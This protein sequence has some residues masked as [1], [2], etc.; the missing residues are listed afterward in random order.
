MYHY[1]Y[2]CYANESSLFF[3]NQDIIQSKE[4]VQQG[5]PLGPFLF[6]LAINDLVSSCESPLNLWYLDDRTLGGS[7]TQ[8]IQD[9]KRI[10]EAT[11]NLG[12]QINPGKCE[13]YLVNPLLEECKNALD[14]FNNVTPGVKLLNKANLKLLGAP[15][16]PEAIDSILE[17]KLENLILMANRLKEIDAHDA[18]FLLRNCFSMPKLTYHL[19]TSPCFLKKETLNKYDSIIKESLQD[20]LNVKLD[21]KGWDQSSLPIKFGGLGIKLASEVALPAYLSSVYSSKSTVKSLIPASI[22]ED[23]NTFYENACTEWKVITERE[24]IP[25]NPNF[26]SEWD[27]PIYVKRYTNLIHTAPTR[28]EKARLLAVSSENASDFLYALPIS[29]LGLKLAN[30]SLRVACALRL[31]SQICIQHKCPCGVI[32]D[33]LGR[34]GLLCKLQIGRHPRHAQINDI[35]KRALTTAE[36]PS[37][38]EPTGLCRKDGKRPDGVT[39][40]PYKQ[41]KSLLWDVTCVDSLADSYISLTSET[42]GSAAERAEKAKTALY[43]ELTNVYLF[44]PIAVKIFG[45][46]GRQGHSLV[47]EIGQKLCEITGD[48]KS[49]FYLFQR[50]SMAIQRGNAASILGTVPSSSNLKEVFY[51]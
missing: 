50:I 13:L 37:R 20:I 21:E 12:L 7:V 34:H 1:V 40:F 41:G 8:V 28:K 15:I 31:G 2:Q 35:V 42:P 45:S 14:T 32:V 5:D 25:D 6:S 16:F 43:E 11:S 23:L 4:G 39:L 3:G 38:L 18:L 9:Y 47:K 17:P 10:L 19:R 26:Q 33:S 22:R 49:T 29:S 30:S 44:T 48:K 46:W 27:S 24:N 36:F 51:L